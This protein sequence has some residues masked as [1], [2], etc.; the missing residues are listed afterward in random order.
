M[1][2]KQRLQLARGLQSS[3]FWHFATPVLW[4]TAVLVVGLSAAY[5]SATNSTTALAL[6]AGA[7]GG[8][9]LF[10]L[11]ALNVNLLYGVAFAA[12]P[13]SALALPG[14]GLPINEL[15]LA[16]ALLVALIRNNRQREPLPNFPK[17]MALILLA[18]IVL[19]AALNQSFDLLAIKR[20]GHLAL[21]C[22]LY[23]AIGAGL[24]PRRVMQKGMLI[25]LS[26]A[27]ATGIIYLVVGISPFGYRGRLTGLLFGDP[28]PAALAILALGFLS[29]EIVRAGWRRNSAFVLLAVPM[30]LT[31]SRSALVA[32]SLCF[33]WWFVARRLR[34]SAGIAVIGGSAALVSLVPTTVQDIGV[35]GSRSGS[36]LLRAAILRESIQSA[37]HGFWFG[38]GPGTAKV[39]VYGTYNFY[40]HNSY[41]AVIAEGGIVAAVAVVGLILFEFIRLIALP[42][43]LRNTWIEMS[44]IATATAAFH[45]GEV[46]LNLPA[47]VAIGFCIDWIARPTTGQ[48]LAQ[49]TL[50][51]RHVPQS[52]LVR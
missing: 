10:T 35:F 40:F 49:P 34:P 25:G 30:L 13:M 27:S 28:N 17:L 41:F 4:A 20:I 16:V 51:R 2:I 48:S 39:E 12:L 32:A 22:G 31:Q 3:R 9:I 37:I 46:L 14:I 23:L 19:A 42:V 5:G 21:Y 11:F 29:I 7:A 24:L 18:A 52:T 33:V 47:A 44:L 8:A 36:D 26:L 6:T 15:L 45:L 1:K 50:G 43:V 38:N